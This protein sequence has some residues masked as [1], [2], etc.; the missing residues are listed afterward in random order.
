MSQGYYHPSK[1]QRGLFIF[2]ITLQLISET[3][4]LYC[5]KDKTASDGHGF[6]ITAS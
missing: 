4:V 6:Q 1:P 3:C 2:L 5:G